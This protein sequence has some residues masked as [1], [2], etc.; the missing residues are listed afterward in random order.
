[1]KTIIGWVLLLWAALIFQ[2]ARPEFFG[3]GSLVIP[4]SVGCIFWLRNGTGVQIA[5][6]A[7]LIQWILSP[8]FAP[9]DVVVI[10]VFAC[11]AICRDRP[12]D[13]GWPST[14]TGIRY[15]WW[16]RPAFVL[17]VGLTLHAS[18]VNNFQ[19][20]NL[21]PTLRSSLCVALPVLAMTLLIARTADQFGLR[22]RPVW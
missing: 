2:V 20:E 22:R 13:S 10:L 17:C 6:A 16:F 14:T 9:I 12:G 15:A 1:M 11:V 21:W 4:L 18:L 5:A 19:A 8:S 3:S 7:L